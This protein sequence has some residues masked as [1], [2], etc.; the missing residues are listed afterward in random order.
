MS[1]L[2]ESRITEVTDRLSEQVASA[3]SSARMELCLL[4]LRSPSATY[5]CN[6]LLRRVHQV[7]RQR[8]GGHRPRV[9]EQF[10]PYAKHDGE[11]ADV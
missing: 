10:D 8:I 5:C 9:D 1:T 7:I 11:R 2:T 6:L 4:G 3:V